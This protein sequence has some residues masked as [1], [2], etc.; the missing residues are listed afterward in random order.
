LDLDRINTFTGDIINAK[1]DLSSGR[2]AHPELDEVPLR[3][4]IGHG[5]HEEAGRGRWREGK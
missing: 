2:Q 4:H 1:N 5:R 3:A